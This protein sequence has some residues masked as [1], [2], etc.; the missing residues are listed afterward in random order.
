MSSLPIWVMKSRV[1]GKWLE[2][3]ILR[4]Q[5]KNTDPKTLLDLSI[6]SISI[7]LR[8]GLAKLEWQ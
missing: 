4:T 7:S 1:G 8:R 2:L 6:L 5:Y 3:R